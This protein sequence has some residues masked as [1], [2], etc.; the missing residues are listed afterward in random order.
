VGKIY[1]RDSGVIA[2]G[3]KITVMFIRIHI[4]SQKILLLQSVFGFFIVIYF[5]ISEE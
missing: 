1:H 3:L 2:Q 4:T 5:Y